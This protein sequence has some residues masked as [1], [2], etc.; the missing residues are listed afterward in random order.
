MG[1]QTFWRNLTSHG[2]QHARMTNEE[3]DSKSSKMIFPHVFSFSFFF[4]RDT[5]NTKSDVE[6]R[7]DREGGKKESEQ[8]ARFTV[9]LI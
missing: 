1:S 7:N 9:S 6:R 3:T 8:K 4:I 5:E 2:S